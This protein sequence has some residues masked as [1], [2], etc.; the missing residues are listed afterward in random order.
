MDDLKWVYNF[1]SSSTEGRREMKNLLGGKG[2]NL[3]EMSSLNL[4]V[5]PG[6]TLTTEA[7]I[8]FYKNDEKLRSSIEDQ[9]LESLKK[10][11]SLTGKKFGDPT[12][13]LLFS[14]RSGA[15]VSMPGMM[16][17]ILNLGLNAETVRGLSKQTGNSWFAWDSYRRFVQMF[18]NVV[19]GIE[20]SL[21]ESTL[22]DLKDA[23]SVTQESELSVDDLVKLTDRY[24][25]LIIES[26]GV[27]FPEDPWEQLWKAISA[28]FSSWNNERAYQY[29]N[30]NGFSHDWGTAVNIQS[31]VFGNMGNES[32]TG[33]CFTR[34]PS[35]GKNIFFGEFLMNAQGEDVVAGIR[36]PGPINEASKNER[37]E[38]FPT[39]QSLM[40]K[41]YRELENIYKKLELHYKDMQ[42][43]E[44][45]IEKDKLYILQ[46][47]NGKRTALSAIKIVV[48]MVNEGLITKEEAV[49]K[50]SPDQIEQ[51]LHP[52]LDPS[53]PRKI[54]GR[55]LPASPGAASGSV[56]FSSEEAVR[57][58][59]EG[60]NVILVR[61]ETS[62]ED[63]SGM[64]AAQG[65]LTARGG[66]TSHAAVVARG[67]G[68][69]CVAG[70]NNIIVDCI[71]NKFS[72]SGETYYEGDFITIEGSEGSVMSGIVPTISAEMTED[73]S[74]FM[75]WVDS[76]KKMKIRT[77][78]DTPKDVQAALDLGAEGI[79]LCRTEHM[80]FDPERV[81]LVREMIFAENTSLRKKAL[82][83]IQPFQKYD[84]LNIFKIME[85][86]PVNVRLLDPPLHE[87]LPQN[88]NEQIELSNHLGVSK[89]NVFETQKRLEEFNPM[90][91][92]RGCRLAISYPEI[93]RMQVSAILEAG[94][95][96]KAMGGKTNIEIMVPLVSGSDELKE[97]KKDIYDIAD[98]LFAEKKDSI[99]F[100]IGTMI[101]LPRAAICAGVI[102]KEAE[103][104]SFGT[105]DLTQTTY[106]LSRDD[107]VKFLP[108]YINK[109]I[110]PEDP[111]VSLDKDGVGFLVKFAAVE[112]KK[113]NSKLHIGIC[114]E[115]GGDPKSIEF[116]ADLGFDYISC[117][118][119]RVPV[120][121]IAAAQAFLKRQNEK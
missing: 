25:E 34:D 62:P 118:P 17:T 100:K 58:S 86:K 11:E 39:L 55:G 83:K 90:L 23:R 72:L 37:N 78:A 75:N 71:N 6:F 116:C 33:V 45:T 44:F 26:Q 110:F 5:P 43:I 36:V 61:Q 73:F 29:R 85:G 98:K 8:D 87:F 66:M 15:R 48:D 18:G 93:Y 13:P 104:F 16:D 119:Y 12:N 97:I 40:P 49:L 76:F 111:F 35:D 95:E 32:G 65:V 2:A 7:C 42:D 84:F 88:K 22:E 52:R 63:I 1:S 27:A 103:F 115:H 69:P 82:D 105:N 54:I 19:L 46:T 109:G 57:L 101:E 21:F 74:L 59:S 28:V 53:S 20:S 47:R 81:I 30:L 89:E 50:V 114:G 9:V 31:M 106:G 68:K 56:V 38:S 41:V 92:H 3:A 91:G 96:Y 60:K 94:L 10:V 77:N 120:A 79:G 4:P 64:I 113:S 108:D 102:A 107:S 80:F 14:I 24:K 99:Q 67:M 117:S 70:C 51:L 112:G 121:R